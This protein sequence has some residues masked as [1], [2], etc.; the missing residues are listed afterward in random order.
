MT[1]GL[2]DR[3]IGAWKLISYVQQPVDGSPSFHPLGEEPKGIIMR[4]WRRFRPGPSDT[5]YSPGMVGTASRWSPTAEQDL[6]RE[7]DAIARALDERGAT[8]RQ[9]LFEAVGARYWGPGRFRGALR[10]ALEEGR[11]RRLSR[12]TFAPP[13]RSS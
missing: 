3:L 11:A 4:G 8:D 12:D 2:R 1:D 7:I 5:L 10:E 6:D 9:T 13:D